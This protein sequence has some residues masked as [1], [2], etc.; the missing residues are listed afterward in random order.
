MTGVKGETYHIHKHLV[1]LCQQ[2]DRSAQEQLYKL[3][4]RAMYNICRRIMGDEDEAQ[5]ILQESFIDAFQKLPSLRETGT[6][7]L[8]L[9]RIVTNNCIN[10][11]R[12]RKLETTGWMIDMM[13]WRTR[14]RIWTI[15]ITR[16]VR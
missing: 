5:D 9:K 10:A 16:S 4:A 15:P 7:P 8:W 6:F 13:R 1:E 3:Y 11:I 14:D 2:G 12:K